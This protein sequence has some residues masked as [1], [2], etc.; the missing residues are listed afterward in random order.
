M[1]SKQILKK[2]INNKNVIQEKVSGE[3]IGRH[4]KIFQQ[5]LLKENLF[6]H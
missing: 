5:V 3:G 2:K 4:I 1:K 6:V